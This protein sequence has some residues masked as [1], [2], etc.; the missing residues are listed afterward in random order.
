MRMRC[1][2]YIPNHTYLYRELKM[3]YY[4]EPQIEHFITKLKDFAND[5]QRETLRWWTLQKQKTTTPSEEELC[6]ICY[7]APM[8]TVFTPCGHKSCNRCISLHLLNKKTCFFCNAW[9][10]SVTPISTSNK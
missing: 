4:T 9:I 1:V 10:E 6:P 5:L 8:D 2:F 7:A 3:F